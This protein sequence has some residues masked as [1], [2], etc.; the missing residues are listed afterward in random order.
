M[1]FV[2][3]VSWLVLDVDTGH[4]EAGEL[5]AAGTATGTAT[6]IEQS[7][8]SHYHNIPQTALF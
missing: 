6:Q 3:G 2:A 5:I 8:F 7:R 1:E 4:V